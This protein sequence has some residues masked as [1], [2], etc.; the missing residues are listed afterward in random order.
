[1]SQF[2]DH[3]ESLGLPATF[4]YKPK[5]QSECDLLIST[6]ALAKKNIQ[7][8]N[9][10]YYQNQNN[11][12]NNT[13]R[14]CPKLLSQYHDPWQD[15]ENSY[16]KSIEAIQKNDRDQSHRKKT[17]FLTRTRSQLATQ[18]ET[19]KL[20]RVLLQKDANQKILETVLSDKIT[21]KIN[22]LDKH[23][24]RKR[25]LSKSSINNRINSKNLWEKRDQ[26]DSKRLDAD[27]T[28]K[29]LRGEQ[30]GIQMI[31]TRIEEDEKMED[32]GKLM[33]GDK[34]FRTREGFHRLR[35]DNSFKSGKVTYPRESAAS[36]ASENY[37]KLA[38]EHRDKFMGK[39]GVS[40]VR[41]NPGMLSTR[42]GITGFNNME[43]FYKFPK[44]R[45]G[46]TATAGNT[47][48]EPRREK[49]LKGETP[50]N[51]DNEEKYHG[52]SLFMVSDEI[53]EIRPILVDEG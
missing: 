49:S 50:K 24:E 11:L 27:L 40:T 15:R 10:D 2:S 52:P 51:V 30:E 9:H 39:D 18:N 46:V 43:N 12:W 1:M 38:Q 32:C 16:Q 23:A 28:L 36:F 21:D 34:A 25:I 5:T 31:V 26:L 47:F 4:D 45:P 41:G 8:K 42:G 35:M 48:Y 17:E 7:P 37:A 44:D 14:H 13:S 6:A 53:Q 3:F 19:I 29:V 20:N 22:S 33:L